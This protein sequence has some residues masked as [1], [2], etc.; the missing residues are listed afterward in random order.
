[1]KRRF[2]QQLTLQ[3]RLAAWAKQVREQAA[4]LDPGPEKDALLAKVVQAETAS[5]LDRLTGSSSLPPSRGRPLGDRVALWQNTALEVTFGPYAT[6]RL[7]WQID[8]LE[9]CRARP[10]S[11]GSR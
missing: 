6:R 1:M 2:K 7:T 11:L 9:R 4:A 8:L 5:Q 3:D 10:A